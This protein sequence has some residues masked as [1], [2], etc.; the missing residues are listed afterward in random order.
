MS[1]QRGRSTSQ[2]TEGHHSA[3][4]QRPSLNGAQILFFS[5]FFSTVL[6]NLIAFIAPIPPNLSG[7]QGAEI[8]RSVRV[9]LG[10]NG[11]LYALIVTPN[12]LG[13]W[14]LAEAANRGQ[15]ALCTAI[16][17]L[18]VATA[19][20]RGIHR[21]FQ[22]AEP[23]RALLIGVNSAILEPALLLVIALLVRRLVSRAPAARPGRL[24]SAAIFF[25]LARSLTIVMSMVTPESGE[26]ALNITL[27]CLDFFQWLTVVLMLWSVR[28][29]QP[30]HQGP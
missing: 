25:I 29:L 9:V 21:F 8:T 11:L 7:Q 30:R 1:G 12:V 2:D 13:V 17:S 5:L 4:H 24:V 15:R 3:G 6:V 22:G 20:V 18:Y 10:Y 19:W 23:A 27:T 14:R 16:A 26:V 28:H